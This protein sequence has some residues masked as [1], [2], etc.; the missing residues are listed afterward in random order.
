MH[1]NANSFLLLEKTLRCVVYPCLGLS[2]S[3]SSE[4]NLGLGSKT[5]VEKQELEGRKI[6]VGDRKSEIIEGRKTEIR[7]G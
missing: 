6:K 2:L 7:R 5:S 4:R 3:M 1:K